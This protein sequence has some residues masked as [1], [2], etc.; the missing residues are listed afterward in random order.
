MAVFHRYDLVEVDYIAVVT[1]DE[2]VRQHVH[3]IFQ[4]AVESEYALLRRY[5]YLP[6]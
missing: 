1:P 6:V 4:F 5:V 3:Q 2:V